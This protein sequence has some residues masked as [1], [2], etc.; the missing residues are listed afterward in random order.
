MGVITLKLYSYKRLLKQ[1][2]KKSIHNNES[3]LLQLTLT[4]A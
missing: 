2:I 3:A 1:N 4:Q